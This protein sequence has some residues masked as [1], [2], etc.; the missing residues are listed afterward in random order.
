MALSIAG[1]WLAATL[2]L[3]ILAG[4]SVA[5]QEEEAPSGADLQRLRQEIDELRRRERENQERIERLEKTLEEERG[6]ELPSPSPESSLEKALEAFERGEGAEAPAGETESPPSDLWSRPLGAATVRLMDISL[7]VLVAAGG[8][9]ERDES[10]ESLQGGDHDPRKRGFTLQ[11]VELSLVGAVDPYFTAETHIVYFLEPVDGESRFEL[12][13]AF[14]TTTQL[15]FGIEEHGL[16]IE[17]GHFFTEYGRLNPRHPHAWDWLDQPVINT[18][19]F[20][21]D[22]LR[23]PGI[24]L[25]WLTPLPW[26]TELHLGMQ[27]ASGETTTSFL[28]SGE[29]F[30]DRAIGGRPFE[31]RDVKSVEDFVYL[32]RLDSSWDPSDEVTTKLGLS[33][34]AGPNATGPDGHTYIYG[35]D[36]L[37]K[38]RPL[39]S[40]HGWPFVIWQSE[41]SRRDYEAD[42]FSDG[43]VRLSS[44]TLEDWGLYTQLLYGFRRD[45]AAG[46]RYEYAGGNGSSINVPGFRGFDG[47]S[48]DPFRNDRHRVSPLVVWQPTEFSR[49]RLQYNYDHA[50]HLDHDQAHSTWLGFEILIGKHPAHVY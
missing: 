20:G 31:D 35:V 28:A 36:F 23:A 26:F 14:L 41:F 18:R 2:P 13:E 10:L 5:A 40:D 27:N 32:V 6:E 47:R 24:R 49:V 17:L 43:G 39:D 1:P 19:L 16:Q 30:E 21:P 45:W 48:K 29:F 22:G 50:R 46:V 7:D 3:F 8:S 9:T 33:G 38:W 42:D 34:L 44:R 37:L 11:N 25:G 4:A 12:E 15:P